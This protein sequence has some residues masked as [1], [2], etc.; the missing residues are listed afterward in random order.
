MENLIKKI[1]STLS[2]IIVFFISAF[3]YFNFKGFAYIDGRIVLIRPEASA[4]TKNGI[5]HVLPSNLAINVSQKFALGSTDAPL[6]LY[7]YSSLGCPHCSDFHLDILPKLKTE[8]I[9]SGLLRVIFVNFPLD[10]KSMKAAMVSNCMTYENYFGF[11]NRLFERQRFWWLD[12]DDE[13]LTRYAAEYG[14]TYDEVQS[15]MHNDKVAEEI[16]SNRQ[17]AITR[18]G[19]KG[20]PA[21][22]FHGKDGNEII[23]GTPNYDDLKLYLDNRLSRK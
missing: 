12:S 17:E 18:L 19:I 7:E 10:K 5:A 1:S 14:L 16:V 11:L 3:F 2:L 6:T 13:Q 20:T 21:F 15:C 9:D 22:F 8:Y 23:Y 4:A